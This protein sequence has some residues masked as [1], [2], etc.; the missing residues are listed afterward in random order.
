MSEELLEAERHK[1]EEL[2]SEAP[3]LKNEA[4]TSLDRVKELAAREKELIERTKDQVSVVQMSVL[5]SIC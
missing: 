4:Q 2:G 5:F 3:R 1:N